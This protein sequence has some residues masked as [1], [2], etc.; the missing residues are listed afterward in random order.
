VA[1]RKKIRKEQQALAHRDVELGYPV[2]LADG[3]VA[4]GAVR[5]VNAGELIVNVE[6]GGD[7]V[8]PVRA[9]AKIASKKVVVSWTALSPDVQ[10]AIAH[11]LD[12]EDFPPADEDPEARAMDEQDARDARPE[13]RRPGDSP[14]DE[15]PGRDLGSRYGAPPS[16]TSP[17]R[18]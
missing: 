3:G 9:V 4:F 5:A 15:L 6:N 2:F 10:R 7:F 8:V 14:L 1:R 16:I 18:A 11:A 17:R 13:S 12:R